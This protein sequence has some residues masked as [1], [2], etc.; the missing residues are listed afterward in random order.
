MGGT[1]TGNSSGLS[2]VIHIR[3]PGMQEMQAWRFPHRSCSMRASR[4]A[5]LLR[6]LSNSSSI[7]GK[8]VLSEIDCTEMKWLARFSSAS[9][10]A[11]CRAAA[12]P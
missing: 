11:L 6:C 7:W 5:A 3:D 8:V 10:C 2:W 1:S 9:A 4:L 12:D